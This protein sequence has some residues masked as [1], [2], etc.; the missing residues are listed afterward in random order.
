MPQ[1]P[2]PTSDA[3]LSAAVERNGF[4][5]LAAF[6]AWPRAH[7]H[8]GPDLLAVFTDVPDAAFNLVVRGAFEAGTADGRIDAVQAEAAQRGVPLAWL[9][10]PASRP[11]ELGE[12]LVAHGFRREEDALAM[13]LE[14]GPS[15]R[16][17]PGG[18]LR[19]TADGVPGAR[20]PADRT[21]GARPSAH[22]VGDERDVADWARVVASG[23]DLPTFAVEPLRDQTTTLLNASP[24]FHAYLVRSGG[25]A[26]GAASLFLH[27]GVAGIYNVATVPQARGRGAGSAA[28]RAAL[29]TAR[30]RRCHLA[31]LQATAM[32]ASLYR[33]LGFRVRGQIQ[34][35]GWAPDRAPSGRGARGG[36][37]RRR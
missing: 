20:S 36:A 5:Q 33:R 34:A 6:A 13:T 17:A 37:A 1:H 22:P 29:A 19:S 9:V 16:V 11:P 15:D 26:I 35:Y 28:T 2:D 7:V 32:A 3:D 4:A 14:L 21:A 10:G 23:F 25:E 18:P 24:G 12:I 8:D 27:D 30:H 31:V